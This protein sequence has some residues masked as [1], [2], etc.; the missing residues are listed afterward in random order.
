MT[1]DASPAVATQWATR[2][3][4]LLGCVLPLGGLLVCLLNMVV[5]LRVVVVHRSDWRELLAVILFSLSVATGPITSA[6]GIGLAVAA[7]MRTERKSLR[8]GVAP[9]VAILLCLGC[10][11]ITSQFLWWWQSATVI[12]FWR[13]GGGTFI[14]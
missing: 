4:A 14:R 12:C 6:I 8:A 10:L 11:A 3:L 7:I 1:S 13:C 9:F 5:W 2:R